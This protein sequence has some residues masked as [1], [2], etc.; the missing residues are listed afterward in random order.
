[1][2]EFNSEK[3]EDKDMKKIIQLFLIMVS[4][5]VFAQQGMS[6]AEMQQMMQQAKEMEACMA[7]IDQDALMSMSEKAKAMEQEVKSLCQSN[8][9]DEAQKRAME[10]GREIAVNDEMEKMRQ[11]GEMMRG[12]MPK[13]GM[14]TVEEMKKRHICDDY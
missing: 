9:R 7:D 8:K 13:I 6:E 12:M 2:F 14:P 4:M 3:R 5:S 1:L 10:F 11:C